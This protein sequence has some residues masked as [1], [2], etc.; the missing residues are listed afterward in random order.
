VI[1]SSD[2]RRF[3]GELLALDARLL[4]RKGQ[5]A[6]ALKSLRRGLLGSRIS[7]SIEGWGLLAI[8][9]DSAGQTDTYRTA[10]RR[11]LERGIDLGPLECP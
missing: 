6:A 5:V 10:C 11:A 8:A 2:R 1:P 3:E 7:D 9:A 4:L